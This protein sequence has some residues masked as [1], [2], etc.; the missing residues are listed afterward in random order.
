MG[1]FNICFDAIIDLIFLVIVEVWQVT[2]SF[3]DEYFLPTKFLPYKVYLI[4]KRQNANLLVDGV[5][6]EWINSCFA[7]AITKGFIC[8]RKKRIF[9]QSKRIFNFYKAIGPVFTRFSLSS[10][11]F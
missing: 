2:K 7:K 4:N 10:N 5:S 8:Q 11:L 9:E 3:D 6:I 1:H